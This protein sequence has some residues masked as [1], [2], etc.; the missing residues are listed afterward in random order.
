MTDNKNNLQ[1]INHSLSLRKHYEIEFTAAETFTS[2]TTAT[3]YALQHKTTRIG[4]LI[5]NDCREI[6]QLH[7]T[8]AI[9]SFVMLLP[10]QRTITPQAV[11][12]IGKLFT[13][14]DD[15]KHLS[16]QELKTFLSLAFKQM[17]FGKLYA[18]FGYDTLLDWFA[19][20][21]EDRMSEVIKYR[22]NEHIRHTMYEKQRR[23]RSDGDAFGSI[24]DVINKNK[25]E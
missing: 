23:N 1:T 24:K 7:I 5:R 13:E 25:N 20:Y 17:K 8:E 22:E 3:Q 10:A 18:G 9:S 6:V 15:L 14:N 2:I 19:Q 12:Q 16:I 11:L 4:E 21:C